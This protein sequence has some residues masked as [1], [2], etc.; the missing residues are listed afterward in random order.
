MSW[1][2]TTIIKPISNTNPAVLIQASLSADNFF[3]KIASTSN[4]TVLPP[5]SAGNGNKFITPRFADN[6]MQ[7]FT[8]FNTTFNMAPYT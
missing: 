5:S 3:L 8:I 2:M 6:M 1:N 7:K 4:N